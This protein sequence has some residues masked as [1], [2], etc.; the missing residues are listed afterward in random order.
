MSTKNISIDG[1]SK[2]IQE[3]ITTYSDVFQCPREYIVG[4]V[5]QAAA[6]TVG[7]RVIVDSGKY[8]NMLVLWMA[9]IGDSGTNKSAPIQAILEPLKVRDQEMFQKYKD[10]LKAYREAVKD[11]NVSEYPICA[12][13]IIKDHTLEA[14]YQSLA[15]GNSLLLY[16][17]ELYT[18]FSG[19]DRYGGNARNVRSHELS[20]WS[21][22]SI[23]VDRKGQ[24]SL[25][26]DSAFLSMLGGIQP[27]LV[28]E[29]F[30]HKA[31]IGS[32]YPQ[33]WLW[34][35]PDKPKLPKYST[36]ILSGEIIDQWFECI[37]FL[38]YCTQE[39]RTLTLSDGAQ[40]VYIDIYDVLQLYMQK[41]VRIFLQRL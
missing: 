21:G 15:N 16:S 31:L 7:N 38:N 25:F 13:T 3:V 5:F 22:E 24:D 2:N 11:G 41:M 19:G 20:L 33:R 30:G 32:G 17:D 28:A 36:S 8:K 6:A 40:K 37:G 18:H 23:R 10:A 1:L 26:I 35:Y 27:Y 34:L 9:V 4:A 29:S 14:C 12:H 39:K